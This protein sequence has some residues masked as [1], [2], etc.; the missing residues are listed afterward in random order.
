MAEDKLFLD[1]IYGDTDSIMINSQLTKKEDAL[2]I[3]NSLKEEINKGYKHLEIDIDGLFR[4]LLL[5]K[6]KK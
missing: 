2:K 3:A 5:Y 1:V 4:K 6:K